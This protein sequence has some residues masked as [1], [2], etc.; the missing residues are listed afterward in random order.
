MGMDG[1]RVENGW[2]LIWREAIY[3][4]QRLLFRR[5]RSDASEEFGRL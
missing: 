3:Q 4:P 1:A 5:F 2:V